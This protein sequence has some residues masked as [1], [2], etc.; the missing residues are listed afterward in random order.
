[1]NRV[2]AQLFPWVCA[3]NGVESQEAT[4][5]AQKYSS[6]T[7][8]RGGDFSMIKSKGELRTS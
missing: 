5:Y 4:L 6:Q 1:M 7:L 3:W 8:P 2:G